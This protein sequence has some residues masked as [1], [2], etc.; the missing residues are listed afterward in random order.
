L[1]AQAGRAWSPL[2]L[3]E[4]NGKFLRKQF[5]EAFAATPR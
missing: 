2:L 4:D 1:G 5:P 3:S